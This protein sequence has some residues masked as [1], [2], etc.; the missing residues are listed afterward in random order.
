M[1]RCGFFWDEVRYF[2]FVYFVS[3]GVGPRVVWFWVRK[4]TV[5]E[6]GLGFGV[7]YFMVRSWRVGYRISDF[8]F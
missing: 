3:F 1:V 8:E 5:L 2:A 7:F 4:P 6:R